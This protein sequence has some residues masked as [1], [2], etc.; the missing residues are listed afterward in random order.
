MRDV[1]SLVCGLETC[2]MR[3]EMTTHHLPADSH[4]NIHFLHP[5]KLLGESASA[6]RDGE[7]SQEPCCSNLFPCQLHTPLPEFDVIHLRLSS[8]TS[9]SF[10]PPFIS[11]PVVLACCCERRCMIYEALFLPA[12]E[13]K[14]KESKSDK[15]KEEKKRE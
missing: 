11:F 5:V 7:G 6:E 12:S 10:I 2:N 4:V 1:S 8:S 3:G 15:E 14:E 13:G 9:H